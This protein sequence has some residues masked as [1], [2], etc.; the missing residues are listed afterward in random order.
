MI[1]AVLRIVGA[2]VAAIGAAF[3]LLIA[4]EFF[5]SIVHP[6]PP[7]FQGTTDEI[8]EHVARYPHW[9][10][11]VVVPMWGV[12]ALI[13]TWL[14]GRLGNHGSAVF[15]AL[16]LLAA[17]ICNVSTLPYPLWFKIVQPTVILIAVVYGYVLLPRRK[18]SVVEPIASQGENL[19]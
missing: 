10:L 15:L 19:S 14:A 17:V 3:V 9:V 13:S 6:F 12:T 2:I 8:S 1:S 7:D 5:S 4:V 16:L 18:L 11:A